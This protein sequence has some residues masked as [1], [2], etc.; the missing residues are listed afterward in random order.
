KGGRQATGQREDGLS[1]YTTYQSWTEYACHSSVM[2]R[3]RPRSEKCL[4]DQESSYSPNTDGCCCGNPACAWQWEGPSRPPS[5]NEVLSFLRRPSLSLKEYRNATTGDMMV[6]VV[7][8]D[9]PTPIAKIIFTL[10][11][12][13][14]YAHIK[15]VEVNA[16]FRGTGLGFL[17]FKK[18]F[19][20][21]G[22]LSVP[23]IRL[24][25]EED[26]SR[27]NRLVVYYE[28]LG[29][30]RRE[31]ARVVYLN[32]YDQVFRKVPMKRR[33]PE[34][35]DPSS[36]YTRLVQHHCSF[37]LVRLQTRTGS[38]LRSTAEG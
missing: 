24:E 21:L 3:K 29:F 8:S 19:A 15:I 34:S 26:T 10:E 30:R 38:F 27:H 14:S 16:D 35:Q 4:S 36:K 32:H 2:Q 6:A 13:R 1:S 7:R 11:G 23:E 20:T 33:L 12:G 22:S 5:S 37:R 18:V 17:L 25:A 9:R 31:G 28:S